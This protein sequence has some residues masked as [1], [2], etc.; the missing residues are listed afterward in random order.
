MTFPMF[1]R[2]L[3]RI[4]INFVKDACWKRC[5]NRVPPCSV[6]NT[7]SLCSASDLTFLMQERSKYH[8]NRYVELMKGYK[9]S[10]LLYNLISMKKN[11]YITCFIKFYFL[12]SAWLH[13]MSKFRDICSA[14]IDESSCSAHALIQ[15]HLSL[16]IYFDHFSM[17]I[18]Q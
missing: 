11:T 7:L 10:S 2:Q 6:E 1:T 4:V 17:P 5:R 13:T 9:I 14:L 8:T 12:Y 16:N 15:I 18:I 3:A